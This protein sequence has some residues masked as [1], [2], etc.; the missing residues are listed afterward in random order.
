MTN[1]IIQETPIRMIHGHRRT[2]A[3][4]TNHIRNHRFTRMIGKEIRREVML[5]ISRKWKIGNDVRNRILISLGSM[6]VF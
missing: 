3:S 1:I 5:M 4:V 6:Y 2:E